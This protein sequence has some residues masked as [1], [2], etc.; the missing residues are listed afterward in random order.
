MTLG[1]NFEGGFE[2]IDDFSKNAWKELGKTVI[3]I[4]GGPISR[5]T[6]PF[7]TRKGWGITEESV[8]Y[9]FDNYT[10]GSDEDD[11]G[12][13]R[14]KWLGK[15]AAQP[16]YSYMDSLIELQAEM[17][18][19]EVIYV[20][21]VFTSDT[22]EQYNAIKYLVDNGVNV[23]VIEFGNEV[24]GKYEFNT[25]N[26]INTCAPIISRIKADFPNI[27]T[28]LISGN[29]KG[30]RD[31]DKWNTELAD[32]VNNPNNKVDYVTL[33][34]YIGEDLAPLAYAAMPAPKIVDYSRI[35]DELQE[36]CEHYIDEV[37]LS[38]RFQEEIDMAKSYYN[39]GIIVTEWNNNPAAVWCNTLVNAM[40]LFSEYIT[41]QDVDYLCSHN[42]ISPD[43]Y[44][45]ICQNKKQDDVTTDMVIRSGYYSLKL[46]NEVNKYK[47]ADP[48][49]DVIEITEPG[50]YSVPFIT[51]NADT[52]LELDT[53]L[54]VEEIK[55]RYIKGEYLYSSCGS[56]G[57]QSK[58]Q[59]KN[60]EIKGVIEE[61]I[62][63]L[64]ILPTNAFG[65][66]YIKT[67]KENKAPIADAGNDKVYYITNLTDVVAIT[68]DG[69]ASFDED[70]T[71]TGYVWYKN[72]V[73]IGTTKTVTDSI[74]RGIHTYKLSVIDNE[75]AVSEDMI[76]ITVKKKRKP[77]WSWLMPKSTNVKE[78]TK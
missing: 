25:V 57:F 26:Y 27:K 40:W 63:N 61:T 64:D 14:E 3:R 11:P 19:L 8:N 68:L 18:E 59:P 55:L 45:K 15:C 43:I 72:D 5:F 37:I 35:D 48:I 41:L 65:Y 56:V 23:K 78:P 75:G 17:P 38:G 54:K 16:D 12:G 9:F 1:T 33:H 28:S 39:T 70:G 77:F 10:V 50:E 69:S 62:T 32:Y 71:I 52:Y 49:D 36:A 67:A 4:P 22:D 20:V 73:I 30:R 34:F 7:T 60:Y 29:F 21:N 51:F 2:N 6:N 58:D 66:V 42:G 47:V 31:H 53:P 44:G 76:T 74:S 46:A 24:Y 13:S